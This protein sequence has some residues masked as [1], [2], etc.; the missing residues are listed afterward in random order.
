VKAQQTGYFI[1]GG[2]HLL[3]LLWGVFAFSN[4]QP[5]KLEESIPVEIVSELPQ[6][7]KG[8]KQAEKPLDAPKKVD[9]VKPEEKNDEDDKP[10]AK[11]KIKSAD[12]LPPPPP[13]PQKVEVKPAPPKPAPPVKQSVAQLDS[14]ELE[15]KLAE[16]A[17][18][19]KKEKAAK[20]AKD[21]AAK[22]AKDKAAKEL[23]AK[24]L[25]Q[26]EAKEKAEKDAKDSKER[27]EARKFDPNALA[28]KLGSNA[29][30]ADT[31]PATSTERA[32]QTLAPKASA[33]A[34]SG[35]N[36]T[37]TASE[38]AAIKE[39]IEKCWNTASLSI[40]AKNFVVKLQFTMDENGNV[41][42][43]PVVTNRQAGAEFAAAAGSAVR[44]VRGCSPL[45]VPK[46]KYEAWK[47][48]INLTFNLADLM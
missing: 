4:A 2:G 45:P 38:T 35:K 43:S 23:V 25:A 22:D 5:M 10:I 8:E 26:K 39:K 12:S 30:L 14:E 7:T 32:G 19:Q 27:L 3:L 37:L 28:K 1:S 31:R 9:V 11:E 48:G 13:L 36:S 16:L 24:E 20:E 6:T 21:K 46:N 47:E 34:Q 15:D 33:G 40:N 18:K 42:G 29:P 41:T 17:A 44:A